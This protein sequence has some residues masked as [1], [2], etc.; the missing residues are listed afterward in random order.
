MHGVRAIRMEQVYRVMRQ[1]LINHLTAG[2]ARAAVFS[3]P[4]VYV[5]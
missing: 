2:P 5:K 1:M 4:G 3:G